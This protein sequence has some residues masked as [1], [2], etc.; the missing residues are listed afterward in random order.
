MMILIML[1]RSSRT[2]AKSGKP[3]LLP[4]GRDFHGGSPAH[5][6]DIHSRA[7]TSRP[8]SP[9]NSMALVISSCCSCR[10]FRRSGPSMM[11][12]GSSSVRSVPCV[13][14]S[15]PSSFSTG[16]R[17][18]L[19]VNS[20]ISPLAIG[21]A[22][23]RTSSGCSFCNIFWRDFPVC[24]QAPPPRSSPPSSGW[25]QRAAQQRNEHHR[26]NGG[27]A[28][29]GTYCLM[30]IVDSSFLS[31]RSSSFN[32]SFAFFT[33]SL[34]IFFILMRLRDVKRRLR[35]RKERDNNSRHKSY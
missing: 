1:S 29:I 33:S 24:K 26:R 16:K 31:Y 21:A 23:A 34:A 8:R 25:S 18:R 14:N 30:R 2:P 28:D 20:H 3:A 27:H 19:G 5:R 12:T 4:S 7:I 6:H 10:C 13:P 17:T 32:T 15:F 35:C 9:G 22:K 11:V